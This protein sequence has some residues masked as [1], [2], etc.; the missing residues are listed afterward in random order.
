[1]LKKTVP[2][3]TLI[4]AI[5][6]IKWFE[7]IRFESYWDIK[8]Y[9]ICYWTKSKVWMTA[10]QS[11]CDE[12][13]RQRVQSEL[14]RINA[15]AWHIDSNK[16]VALISLFYNIWYK[17]NI[18]NYASRWDDKSVIYIMRKYNRAWWK[19]LKGLQIRRNK[20]ILYYL[21]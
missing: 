16:K 19:Y 15:I 8:Q 3:K 1:M 17:G 13:L 2:N 6:L 18:L 12:M 7:W 10:T 5:E 14:D 9:S 11:Q 4:N 20:E 21:K